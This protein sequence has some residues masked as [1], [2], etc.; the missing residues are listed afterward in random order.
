MNILTQDSATGSARNAQK[1]TIR[2]MTFIKIPLKKNKLNSALKAFDLKEFVDDLEY[3]CT[4]QSLLM[5]VTPT[6]MQ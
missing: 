3:I 4:E 2:I 6:F 5:G 1:N